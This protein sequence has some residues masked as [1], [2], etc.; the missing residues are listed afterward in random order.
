MRETEQKR[1]FVAFFTYIL[2][3]LKQGRLGGMINIDSIIM[4]DK[5]LVVIAVMLLAVLSALAAWLLPGEGTDEFKQLIGFFM[6]LA[7]GL[8]GLVTGAAME[9]AKKKV[10]HPVYGA[11]AKESK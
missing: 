3:N 11:A 4:N 2:C 5:V 8:F 10:D 9:R 7:S 6:V 1:T